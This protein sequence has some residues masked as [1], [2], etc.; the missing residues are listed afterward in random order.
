MNLSKAKLFSTCMYAT[1]N[2]SSKT[3][4]NLFLSRVNLNYGQFDVK[5]TAVETW[6]ETSNKMR[7]V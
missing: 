2:Q 7:E 4:K 5:Y 3:N 1:V 6:N